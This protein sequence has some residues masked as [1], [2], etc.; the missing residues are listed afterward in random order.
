MKLELLNVIVWITASMLSLV[1]LIFNPSL[2]QLAVVI[3]FMVNSIISFKKYQ[4][5]KSKK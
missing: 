5:N 1:G 3:L 2:I 4:K